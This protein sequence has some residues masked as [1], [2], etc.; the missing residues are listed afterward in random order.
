MI[1]PL[2]QGLQKDDAELQKDGKPARAVP[3]TVRQL[4]AIVRI[5]ESFAKMR[6]SEVAT[7][8]DVHA[9][10]DLFTKSTMRAAKMGAI[11]LEGGGGEQA[12]LRTPRHNPVTPTGQTRPVLLPRPVATSCCNSTPARGASG[13][14]VRDAHQGPGPH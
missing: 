1:P 10:I 3:I 6:L 14:H 4:E 8:D 13:A 12:R 5:S 7:E 9:A 2:F 11:Q